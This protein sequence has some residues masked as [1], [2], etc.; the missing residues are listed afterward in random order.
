[1]VT[2]L[3]TVLEESDSRELRQIDLMSQFG[4]FGILVD[5]EQIR[6]QDEID[7]LP[8]LLVETKSERPLLW[9]RYRQ[10]TG[11]KQSNG[12][13]L[14]LRVRFCTVPH[15]KTRSNS[16]LPFWFTGEKVLRLRWVFL[17]RL[18][19]FVKERGRTVERGDRAG[20]CRGVGSIDEVCEGC[21]SVS[22]ISV[23]S[24]A[25]EG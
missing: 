14:V 20:T 16:K 19:A 18:P 15:F 13:T 21:D 8:Y 5:R 17:A 7:R 1:V 10:H 6:S 25:P 4:L 11:F 23:R 12:R 2:L 24:S 22:A 9:R 3:L